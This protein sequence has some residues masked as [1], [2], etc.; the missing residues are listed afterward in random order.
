MKMKKAEALRI[1]IRYAA[2]ASRGAGTGIGAGIPEEDER[3][4]IRDAVLW[5]WKIAY[6]YEASDSD[7]MNLGLPVKS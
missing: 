6:G 4:K 1:L 3:K 5:A 7:L 2:S